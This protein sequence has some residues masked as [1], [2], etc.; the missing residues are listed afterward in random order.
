M[1]ARKTLSHNQLVTEVKTQLSARFT[2]QVNTIRT[3][4][5]HLIEQEYLARDEKDRTVYNYLA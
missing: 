4:I 1:K 2:P 3:R 5:E